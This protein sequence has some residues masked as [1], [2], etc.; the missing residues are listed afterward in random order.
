MAHEIYIL[1]TKSKT[2]FSRLIHLATAAPY[3]HVSIGLDGLHG[4]FYSFGRKYTRLC[5]PAGLVKEVIAADS[6]QVVRYQLYRLQ[7]SQ[8]AYLRI[9]RR[10][11]GMYRCRERYHYSILG[12][13]TAFFNFPLQRRSHYF[14]SQFVA[15][16]LEQ[17]GVMEFGKNAALVRPVDFCSLTDLQLVSEGVIGA[18]GS[19]QALPAPSEVV[20]MLPFGRTVV[21]LCRYYS[22]TFL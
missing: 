7:V 21:Q 5:L 17:C 12:A 11:Q 16:M 13:L 1:I 3:T 4:D 6:P 20:L 2:C 22:N 18:F 19:K 15:E 10:L 14:C 9:R 8:S